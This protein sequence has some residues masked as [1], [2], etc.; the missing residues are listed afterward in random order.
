MRQ[1]F[2][3]ASSCYKFKS[4]KVMCYAFEKVILS[5]SLPVLVTLSL[6]ATKI[7][8]AKTVSCN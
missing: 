5:L 3:Y 8:P 4:F 6:N 7:S 2:D 1:H